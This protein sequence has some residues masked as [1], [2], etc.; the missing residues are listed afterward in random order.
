M[1]SSN[2]QRNM[3]DVGMAMSQ[4]LSKNPN[5]GVK[6]RTTC[7]HELSQTGLYYRLSWRE[8]ILEASAI[9]SHL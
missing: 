4:K 6:F 5:F 2:R 9:S 1:H 3:N 7:G 8:G